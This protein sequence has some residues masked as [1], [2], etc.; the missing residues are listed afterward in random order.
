MTRRIRFALSLVLVSFALTASACASATGP[1]TETCDQ[2][3]P[4]TCHH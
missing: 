3:N 1:S 4:V 2:S